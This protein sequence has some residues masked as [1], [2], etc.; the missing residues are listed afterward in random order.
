MAVFAQIVI[1]VNRTYQH[2]LV[3]MSATTNPDVVSINPWKD[4]IAG[5]VAGMA[6]LASGH[7]FDTV[8]VRIQSQP[9]KYPSSSFKS[10]FK[11]TR[12]EGIHGL[13]KGMEAPLM[14]VGFVNALV[15]GVYGN[16]LR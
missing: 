4:F 13:F 10:L 11:I 3:L 7:P 12:S 1:V 5:T 16:S 8:K 14:G 15:F 9:T 6:G 2:Q